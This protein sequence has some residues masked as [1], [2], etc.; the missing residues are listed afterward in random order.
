MPSLAMTQET[1][2]NQYTSLVTSQDILPN[3]HFGSRARSSSPP[4]STFTGLR[5]GSPSPPAA[6][7]VGPANPLIRNPHTRIYPYHDSRKQMRNRELPREPEWE[8]EGNVWMRMGKYDSQYSTNDQEGPEGPVQSTFGGDAD[9]NLMFL[10]IDG[11]SMNIFPSKEASLRHQQGDNE[12]KPLGWIDVRRAHGVSREILLA[13]DPLT[14]QI[15]LHFGNGHLRF[16]LETPE[17]MQ[18]WMDALHHVVY[19]VS[20]QKQVLRD[21]HHK[22]TRRFEA[23]KQILWSAMSNAIES[24]AEVQYGQVCQLFELYDDDRSGDLEIGEILQMVKEVASIRRVNLINFMQAQE[25]TVLT[26][27]ESFVQGNVS[28][29]AQR[30]ANEAKNLLKLYEDDLNEKKLV[31]EAILMKE[32]FDVSHNG[33]LDFNEFRPLAQVVVFPPRL[34]TQELRFYRGMSAF[35]GTHHQP[36]VAESNGGG[37][38]QS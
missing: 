32:K 14:Y 29:P 21:N 4:T 35:Q 23:V 18:R 2:Y 13:E 38:V 24:H 19:D 10:K 15:S 34:V 5:A 33:R 3:R 11:W 16:R 37:C 9:F 17:E 25:K 28:G 30:W 12:C 26:N 1:Q 6:H 7:Q 36:K 20:I 8:I 27:G 31:R 22:R